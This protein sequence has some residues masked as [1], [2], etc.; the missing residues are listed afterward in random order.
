MDSRWLTKFTVL[1]KNLWRLPCAEE[2]KK[3]QELKSSSV[4]KLA[5]RGYDFFDRKGEKITK[6]AIWGEHFPDL[7]VADQ[8]RPDQSKMTRAWSKVFDPDPSLTET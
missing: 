5:P 4:K 1:I 6:F 3:S 8:T 7:E 2:L